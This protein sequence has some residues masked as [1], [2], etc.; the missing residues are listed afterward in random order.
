MADIR[1]F[2]ADVQRIHKHTRAQYSA[3]NPS[4]VTSQLMD[5]FNSYTRG[6]GDL[7]HSILEYWKQTYIDASPNPK[8]EPIQENINWLAV[9]LNF[10]DGELE[11]DQ[12][13]PLNDWK[14]LA[15]L[16]NYEAA[17]LP[18]DVLSSMMT[19]LVDKKAL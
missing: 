1:K 12:D 17:D 15:N 18:I 11:D 2:Y 5:L 19:I 4:V 7:P 13:I 10:L 8:E 14:E 6:L 9:V 16:I 3:H